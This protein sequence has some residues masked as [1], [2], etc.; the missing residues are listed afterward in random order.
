MDQEI[1]AKLEKW[2]DEHFDA[3]LQDVEKLVAVPSV[4]QVTEREETPFGEGCR[5]ALDTALAMAKGYGFETRNYE[6]RC[7]SADND[8]TQKNPEPKESGFFLR[9]RRQGSFL[10][11]E[12]RILPVPPSSPPPGW[13]RSGAL[14]S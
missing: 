6:N 12:P 5:K 4:S 9:G 10:P 11:A 1:R 13:K 14:H 7:G 3:L 2:I 8:N